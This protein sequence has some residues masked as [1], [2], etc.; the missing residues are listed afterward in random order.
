MRLWCRLV[1]VVLVFIASGCFVQRGVPSWAMHIKKP[2]LE[3][4]AG[5][6]H[7]EKRL[8]TELQYPLLNKNYVPAEQIVALAI[9]E[10][11]AGHGFD[12]AVLLSLASYRY[13]QQAIYAVDASRQGVP[14]NVNMEVYNKLV[15]A[16]LEVFFD[17]N[18]NDEIKYLAARLDHNKKLAKMYETGQWEILRSSDADKKSQYKKLLERI[19]SAYT[20]PREYVHFPRLA[21]AFQKRLIADTKSEHHSSF[22]SYYLAETP[23][24]SFQRAALSHADHFFW[25]PICR[26][27]AQRLSVYRDYVIESLR[28]ERPEERS[29]AVITLALRPSEETLA[30]LKEAYKK[31]R[32]KEVLLS[33]E[34]A[35]IKH[36]VG[37]IEKLIA[38]IG[39]CQKDTLCDH[40]IQLLE[41]LPFEEEAKI[42]PDLLVR[43]LTNRENT[44]F[45]RSFAVVLLRDIAETKRLK[46]GHV[47]ALM[48][49][50]RDK[51]KLVSDWAVSAVRTL[52][53]LTKKRLL[54][55]FKE[56]NVPRTALFLKWANIAKP[57][58]IGTLK[59]V[60]LSL[61][62]KDMSEREAVVLA[63]GNMKGQEAASLL[64]D[65]Y[66]RYKDLRLLI[67]IVLL[68]RGDVR[69][70][71]MHELAKMDGKT[72]A[73][74]IKLGI[75]ADDAIV[76]A[77]KLLASKDMNEQIQTIRLIGQFHGHKL[78]KDLWRLGSYS[79]AEYYPADAY[80]RRTALN[81]IL[82]WK[83]TRAK[84]LKGEK[85][86]FAPESGN[87]RDGS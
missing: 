65:Y 57:K 24:G 53:Q 55:R 13:R 33:F 35:F 69:H 54:A 67:A 52:P 30:I 9:S 77:R 16:E 68:E 25:A 4:G 3:P 14:N 80:V 31:E 18:Y 32:T 51:N 29:N 64:I 48:H 74:A 43:I 56:N 15:K 36:G 42:N 87:F 19:E 46:K 28:S 8:V 21:E 83:M 1:F 10:I 62:G 20:A 6:A 44:G 75:G 38:S 2:R 86:E 45:S 60:V 81:V 27:L 63:V 40:A 78:I 17:L 82:W 61:D 37:K 72:A 70:R 22:A 58:D 11:R 7:Y 23:L 47:T 26:R 71:K 84:M 41:W 34:Y 50:T 66:T 79:S 39:N 5:L 76:L 12:A 73:V 85:E 59:R 49:A